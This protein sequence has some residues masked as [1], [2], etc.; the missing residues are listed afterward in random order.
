MFVFIG[1]YIMKS[2]RE[3]LGNIENMVETNVLALAEFPD[4]VT[5][6]TKIAT[7]SIVIYI[8]VNQKDCGK[9]IGKGGKTIDCIYHLAATVKNLYL[10]NDIR[11]FKV[12]VIEANNDFHWNKDEG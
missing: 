11:S 4:D 2:P 1:V 6:E 10:F 3:V 7:K 8:K 12:E 9:V 5:I